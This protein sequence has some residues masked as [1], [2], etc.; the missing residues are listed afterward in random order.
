MKRKNTYLTLLAVVAILAVVAMSWPTTRGVD[1]AD[2]AL[3]VYNVENMTCGACVRRVQNALA[4]VNG[5]GKVEVSVTAGRSNVE[6]DAARVDP[7]T[8]AAAITAA[9]YPA[10]LQESL[11][12]DEYR[13][14]KAEDEHL[15]NRYVARVGERLL[16]REEFQSA[17]EQ[18]MGSMSQP[19]PPAMLNQLRQQV[20]SEVLQRELLLNAAEQSQVVVY[21]DEVFAEI[22]RIKAD[23]ADFDQL[24]ARR[25]GSLEAFSVQLKNDMIISKHL[26]LNVSDPGLSAAQQQLQ[27][28]Y[29]YQQLA[30]TTPLVIFDPALKATNSGSGCGGSCC[31]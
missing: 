1:A 24:L 28:Q 15:A 10:T 12:T 27:L 7:A 5:V 22:E 8:I 3:A 17:L 2:A 4:D 30:R 14:L 18:R 13:A 11:S 31:G 23:H 9:G 25:F 6:Y 20:W 19:P 26:A 21:E 29:W 16:T